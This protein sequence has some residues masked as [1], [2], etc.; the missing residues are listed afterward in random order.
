MIPDS[1]DSCCWKCD[2]SGSFL[3][4]IPPNFP[5]TSF[6]NH[7]FL[8]KIPQKDLEQTFTHQQLSNA[9]R[10]LWWKLPFRTPWFI[11]KKGSD[12]ILSTPPLCQGLTFHLKLHRPI[13]F[14]VLEDT[15]RLVG[16]YPIDRTGE[17]CIPKFLFEV[18]EPI[19]DIY[20]AC[21]T[22]VEHL[23][24]KTKTSLF[25]L[26][27]LLYLHYIWYIWNSFC[28]SSV[29]IYNNVIIIRH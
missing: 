28:N 26:R 5:S 3:C 20:G 4:R 7:L 24:K 14:L 12:F 6:E 22:K 18:R 2:M 27:N 15:V 8:S 25:Y 19:C 23:G 13:A 16:W 21:K 9:S 17:S 29:I 1:G 10:F 11:S